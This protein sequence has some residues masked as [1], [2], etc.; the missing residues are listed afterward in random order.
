MTLQGVDYD[1][2]SRQL[3]R[4]MR[5]RR[6]QPAL[7]RRLGYQSNVV[8]TWESGRRAPAAS[9]LFRIAR[10]RRGALERALEGFPVDARSIAADASG[11]A[12]L[13]GHLR[14]GRRLTELASRCDVSRYTASRWFSGQT[15]PRVG[16]FLRLL[17]TLT[18]RLIDFV[19][20]LT[21]P[22]AVPMLAPHARSLEARRRVAFTHPWSHAI[23][24]QLECADYRRLRRHR[25]G[26]IATRLGISPEL[27]DACLRALEEAG[28][29]RWDGTRHLATEVAVDTSMGTA[30]DRRA[31]R[32]HWADVG[33]AGIER[34]DEGLF[35]WAVVALSRAD[36]ERLRA[37][38][39]QYMHAMRQLVEESSPSEVVVVANVQ[40]FALSQ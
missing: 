28:L 39:V 40:L 36:L 21:G 10:T 13:L 23:L 19:V 5:G 22:D 30:E 34:G 11:V 2:L 31:L 18:S 27:E 25:R 24:R 14:G 26:W 12:T 7:S 3:I 38:H 8:Y 6:S 1:E 15:E 29:T 20:A 37:M 32:L 4:A 9:E 17:E 35:S 33:R 16:E